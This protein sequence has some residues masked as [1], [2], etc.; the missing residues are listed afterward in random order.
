MQ[1]PVELIAFYS[2]IN[3]PPLPP[4]SNLGLTR[5]AQ[6][7][8]VVLGQRAANSSRGV[9]L[10]NA[11][12]FLVEI[13]LCECEAWNNNFKERRRKRAEQEP[14]GLHLRTRWL[15]TASALKSVRESYHQRNRLVGL[16]IFAYICEGNM[17]H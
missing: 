13:C 15:K 7:G 16:C 17:V 3:V 8:R 1:A 2:T 6:G 10:V 9:P 4:I 5:L 14:R 12:R 11:D